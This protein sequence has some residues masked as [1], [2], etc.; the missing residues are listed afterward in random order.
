MYTEHLCDIM[1]RLQHSRI[2]LLKIDI[3]GQEW[4]VFR[5]LNASQAPCISSIGTKEFMLKMSISL[6]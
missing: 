2:D 1:S 4:D 6:Y 5:E 3:E